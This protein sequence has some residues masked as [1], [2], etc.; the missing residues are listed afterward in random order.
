MIFHKT[1]LV[2]V[3]LLGLVSLFAMVQ[4]KEVAYRAKLIWPFAIA[5]FVI[6]LVYIYLGLSELFF[7]WYSDIEYDET[8]P[9]NKFHLAIQ[10]GL[11]LIPMLSVMKYFRSRPVYIIGMCVIV[12][13]GLLRY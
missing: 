7:S 2:A 1:L 6:S 5:V 8:L 13:A 10:W 12:V 11:Y 9:I 3:T 4:S